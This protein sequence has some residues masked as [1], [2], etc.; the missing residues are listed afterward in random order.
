M[1]NLIV[2]IIAFLMLISCE[3]Y[4][5]TGKEEFVGKIPIFNYYEYFSITTP[6]KNGLYVRTQK[7]YTNGDSTKCEIYAKTENIAAKIDFNGNIV[8][9][10]LNSSDIFYGQSSD[11]ASNVYSFNDTNPVQLFKY[12]SLS[13]LSSQTPL[14]FN[15]FTDKTVTLLGIDYWKEDKILGYG[16]IL[17][18]DLVNPKYKQFLCILSI[19]NG[20][21]KFGLD[22]TERGNMSN[23]YKI[24]PSGEIFG[25]ESSWVNGVSTKFLRRYDTDFKVIESKDISLPNH[26]LSSTIFNENGLYAIQ[27]DFTQQTTYLLFLDRN[28]KLKEEKI[29]VPNGGNASFAKASNNQI[30]V[31]I[32]STNAEIYSI[33]NNLSLKKVIDLELPTYYPYIKIEGNKITVS[34]LTQGQNYGK[35]SLEFIKKTIGEPSV[36]K[37]IYKS[38][39]TRKCSR[40]LN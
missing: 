2:L 7:D 20:I 32:N 10:K 37:I 9:E 1:K 19:K 36:R 18:S 5:L 15:K 25:L 6:N 8:W 39:Y 28:F 17:I 30:H 4:T 21:E 3:E 12:D 23:Q 35:P 38:Q 11:G 22:D 26:S 13:N 14:L 40:W 31:V 27:R 24:Y 33:E 16:Q 29:S 34:A